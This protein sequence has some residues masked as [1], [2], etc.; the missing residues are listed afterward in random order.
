MCDINFESSYF[1][2]EGRNPMSA[3]ITKELETLQNGVSGNFADLF[4]VQDSG[5]LVITSGSVMTQLISKYEQDYK[6]KIEIVNEKDRAK[7]HFWS[8]WGDRLPSLSWNVFPTAMIILVMLVFGEVLAHAYGFGDSLGHKTARAYFLPLVLLYL[9]IQ[10]CGVPLLR[11]GVS[12]GLNFFKELE[13]NEIRLNDAEQNLNRKIARLRTDH[14]FFASE[15]YD[16]LK[17]ILSDSRAEFNDLLGKF[18]SA[19]ENPRKDA[20]Q[21]IL[22]LELKRQSILER[23][24]DELAEREFLLKRINY[25]IILNQKFLGEKSE[26]EKQTEQHFRVV[27]DMINQ[28]E[29][30]V[31]PVLLAV[32]TR[33]ENTDHELREIDDHLDPEDLERFRSRCYVEINNGLTNISKRMLSIQKAGAQL[34]ASLPAIEVN[35][36]RLLLD[37]GRDH[38]K[39]LTANV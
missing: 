31:L 9:F 32:K 38:P 1:K 19:Y 28:A 16:H 39:L 21:R 3:V 33:Y 30:D 25:N 2:S 12:R 5:E 35:E 23:N 7:E 14:L 17:G 36:A 4:E 22:K 20:E 37:Q 27:Q 26:E 10:N 18:K 13:A 34:V 24:D 8:L 11:I 29:Q 6:E 15:S